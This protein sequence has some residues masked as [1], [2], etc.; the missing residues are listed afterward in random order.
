MWNRIL[1][2]VSTVDETA[3]I[4]RRCRPHCCLCGPC[5]ARSP[6]PRHEPRSFT[7]S[8]LVCHRSEWPQRRASEGPSQSRRAFPYS[9][10]LQVVISQLP[11]IDLFLNPRLCCL[12]A[13]AWNAILPRPLTTTLLQPPRSCAV[14]ACLQLRTRVFLLIMFPFSYFLLASGA[15]TG[16]LQPWPCVLHRRARCLL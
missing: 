8:L 10:G 7:G 13:V 16:C 1:V 9:R 15:R 11:Q 6:G 12:E 3:G 14:Y 4:V 2:V 5:H